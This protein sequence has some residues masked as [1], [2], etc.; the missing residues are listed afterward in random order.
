MEAPRSQKIGP[1]GLG[2]DGVQQTEANTTVIELGAEKFL[3]VVCT[4][5]NGT[6]DANPSDAPIGTWQ[7]WLSA[8]NDWPFVRVV[9]AET[10]TFSLAGLAAVG[11]TAVKASANFESCPGARAQIR[12]VRGSG[13]AVSARCSLYVTVS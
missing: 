5:D 4:I 11:N 7:L 10:G 13:G 12:Y 6:N 9:E 1:F 8:A 2:A 3:S